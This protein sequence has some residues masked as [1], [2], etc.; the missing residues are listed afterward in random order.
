[1]ALPRV[2]GEVVEFEFVGA[3]VSPR[4]EADELEV[5]LADGGTRVEAVHDGAALGVAVREVAEDLR[6][7]RRSARERCGLVEAVDLL[8]RRG[9][10]AAGRQDRRVDVSGLHEEV[11]GR[12]RLHLAG[13]DDNAGLARAALVERGL[14]AAE[15]QVAGGGDFGVALGVG[16]LGRV[17]VAAVVGPEHN[18]GVIG[19]ARFLDVPQEAAHGLV[20]ALHH[21]GV[22]RVL[23]R[24][25]RVGLVPEVLDEVRPC[26]PG[27]V[28]GKQPEVDEER[29]A[30]ARADERA[31]L[32][33][34]ALV[35][36]PAGLV[37]DRGVG[38]ELP[39]RE[40]AAAGARGPRGVGPV[41]VE[42]LVLRF[43]GVAGG[44][45]V[46]KVPLSEMAGGVARGLERLGEGVVVGLQARDRVRDVYAIAAR[47]EPLLKRHFR[48]V[49]ARCRDAGAGGVLP[50]HDARTRGR[51][52]RAGGIR[53]G[54]PHAPRRQAV[55]V[56]RFVVG[57]AITA[58]VAGAEIIGEDQH[59]V[60][61]LSLR[62]LQASQRREQQ[63]AEEREA[64][65]MSWHSPGRWARNCASD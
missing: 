56:R 49:A 62:C 1:M 18:D 31:G 45:V 10:Y 5:A 21:G 12:T 63:G 4:V 7:W 16:R 42:A 14:A 51:A 33:G 30:L 27:R 3:V 43:V 19:L 34:H 41:H 60:G 57:A 47:Q 26:V 46:P 52:E 22:E 59:D 28:D 6:A 53:V 24:V 9:R 55:E 37:L 8:V 35:D 58:Q 32:V 2:L 40:V 13:P 44:H 39:G 64:G 54:Q 61:R 20:H 38:D 17:G 36:V 25:G 29:P 50:G 65:K 11:G 15:G 23:L 48:E